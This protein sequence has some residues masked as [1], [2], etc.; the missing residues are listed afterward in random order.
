MIPWDNPS[1]SD[2]SRGRR[3]R[4]FRDPSRGARP[5][6]TRSLGGKRGRPDTDPSDESATC[7]SAARPAAERLSAGL[8]AHPTIRK[9]LRRIR[10]KRGRPGR[11]SESCAGRGTAAVMREPERE[12]ARGVVQD[13]V[14]TN[15]RLAWNPASQGGAI[16]A[17]REKMADV[18]VRG[19]EVLPAGS[20]RPQTGP[21]N[22][23][24]AGGQR[25]P[26]VPRV[27]KADVAG[28]R[29]RRGIGQAQADRAA[30]SA[31]QLGRVAVQERRERKRNNPPSRQGKD[32]AAFPNSV[33]SPNHDRPTTKLQ[34]ELSQT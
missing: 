14:P 11:I 21:V 25:A 10:S 6:G 13:Q 19:V 15:Q 28:V 2:G 30:R 16:L 7:S 4:A 17:L 1:P 24:S 29:R 33:D 32:G 5:G 27:L 12:A 22:V 3:Q 18:A 20:R 31:D 26:D 34:Q 23:R 8:A 9:M